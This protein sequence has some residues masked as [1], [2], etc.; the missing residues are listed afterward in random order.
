MVPF[1]KNG[2]FGTLKVRENLIILMEHPNETFKITDITIGCD[3]F[4]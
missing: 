4:I 1:E 2:S 3:F